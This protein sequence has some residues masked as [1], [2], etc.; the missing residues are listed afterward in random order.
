MI[1]TITFY[2]WPP[3]LRITPF[4]GSKTAF[5]ARKKQLT[6]SKIAR[7]VTDYTVFDADRFWAWMIASQ[8]QL[9]RRLF[10]M[11]IIFRMKQNLFI[12][13]SFYGK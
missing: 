2:F 3:W 11:H 5:H 12:V 9:Q 13:S 8:C 1:A 6:K 10:L 4:M 7:D